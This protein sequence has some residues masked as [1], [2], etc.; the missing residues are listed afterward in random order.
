MGAANNIEI[1]VDAALIH[2]CQSLQEG[3]LTCNER[4][5]FYYCDCYNIAITTMEH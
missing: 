1:Q 2:N 5:N 4:K 3:N